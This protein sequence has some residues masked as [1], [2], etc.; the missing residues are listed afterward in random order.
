AK[1]EEEVVVTKVEFGAM[2]V[3]I[4]GISAISA[5]SGRTKMKPT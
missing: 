1:E 4:L 3:E 5:Q 2:T